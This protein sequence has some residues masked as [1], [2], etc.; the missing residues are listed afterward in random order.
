M[1]SAAQRLFGFIKHCVLSF[2]LVC[3]WRVPCLLEQCIKWPFQVEIPRAGIGAA[4][5]VPIPALEISSIMYA[6]N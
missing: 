3:E 1:A 5:T 2:A 6:V 4:S